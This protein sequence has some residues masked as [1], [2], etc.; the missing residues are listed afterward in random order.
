MAHAIVRPMPEA[1]KRRGSVNPELEGAVARFLGAGDRQRAVTE[2]IRGYGPQILGYLSASMRRPDDADDAFG[3][4]CEDVLKGLHGFERRSSVLAWSYRVAWN[5]AL[6]VAQ[7]GYQRRSR[8][9]G[10]DESSELAESVRS[11]T[12][13]HLKDSSKDWLRRAREQLTPEERTLLI[14]RIDRGMSWR[15]VAEVLATGGKRPD[16]VALRKRFARLTR[17]LEGTARAEGLIE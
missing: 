1:G 4:F 13:Q 12:A 16:P 9:L 8:R 11:S 14:L 15:D 7:D 2:I 3:L 6:R 10:T 17:K 5:C